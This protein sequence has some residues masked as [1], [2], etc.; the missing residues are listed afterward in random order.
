MILK[1]IILDI[2]K[3]HITLHAASLK[4]GASSQTIS[5]W[6]KM[7]RE[8]GWAALEVVKKRGRTPGMGRPRKN[9]KPLTELERLRK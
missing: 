2:E 1:K 9:S 3:K 6:L 5:V 4:Y 8:H 7:Y